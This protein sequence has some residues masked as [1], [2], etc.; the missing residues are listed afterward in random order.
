MRIL[1]LDIGTGTQDILLFDSNQTVE[2]SVQ[3]VMPAPTV[4]A[5]ERI[6]A[7][8]AASKPL[9]LT[10][11]NMGG[12]PVTGA[13]QQHIESGFPA[14]ATP[15]AAATF[16]DDLEVVRKMGITITSP[17][18]ADRTQGM[19]VMLRDLDLRMVRRALESFEV[20]PMW[21]ALAVAV[22]DHGNSPPGYSDR[23]FRF[24][25]IKRQ[26]LGSRRDVHSFAY[27]AEEIPE[28]CTRMRAVAHTVDNEFP[29]LLMDTAE[30]AV[31]GSLEDLN[32]ASQQC[33]VVA[34]LGNEHTLAFHLHD[35]TIW[36]VFEHHTHL[37]SRKRLEQHLQDLVN[38]DLDGD[39]IWQEQGHGAIVVRGH[40]GLGFI[41]VIGPMR[42][43]MERSTLK[44]Y[45]ATPHG[46]MM[47]AGSFG[48]VRAWADRMPAQRDEILS[49]LHTVNLS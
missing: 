14:Y 32:V 31:L 19:Q 48:L 38:G 6:K 35:T 1:A 7:C 22:F 42:S 2:N 37:L 16:N 17:E 13:V 25:H 33:K 24:D 18:E 45:F 41:S 27:L 44:P 12:G 3:L 30:A 9:I 43:L 34:N 21:D 10:G 28:H 4:I 39:M 5:A 26:V 47:L 11:T 36:G 29:L 20:Y 8:T 15:S 49:A 23:K 40:E 46:S